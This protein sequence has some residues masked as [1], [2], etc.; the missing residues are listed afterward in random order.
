MRYPAAARLPEAILFIGEVFHPRIITVLIPLKSREGKK[1]LLPC[2][3]TTEVFADMVEPVPDGSGEIEPPKVLMQPD[4]GFLRNVFRILRRRGEMVCKAEKR[5]RM[6]LHQDS[7]GR[8][9]PLER[10]TTEVFIGDGIL[11]E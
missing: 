5:W 8:L 11:I 9:V 7:E 2:Q 3:G 4:E 6:A 1:L 10:A